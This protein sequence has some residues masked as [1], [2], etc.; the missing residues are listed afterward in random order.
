M[1]GGGT[2]CL[3]GGAK[4]RVVS[5]SILHNGMFKERHNSQRQ[6]TAILDTNV[7]RRVSGTMIS[8]KDLCSTS[9][10]TITIVSN[11]T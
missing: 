6:F 2:D 5:F 4:D 9:W 7:A 8:W 1:A 10:I 3:R 11:T